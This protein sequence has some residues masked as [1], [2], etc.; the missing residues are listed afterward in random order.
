LIRRLL[1]FFPVTTKEKIFSRERRNEQGKKQMAPDLAAARV[2]LATP[3]NVARVA[4][5]R[6]GCVI[7]FHGR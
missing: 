4:S 2:P 5:H 3:G 7:S 1:I 6:L